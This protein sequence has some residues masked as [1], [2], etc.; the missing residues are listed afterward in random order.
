MRGGV[1]L[2]HAERE[3][4]EEELAPSFHRDG[5]LDLSHRDRA[6]AAIT[7]TVEP[8]TSIETGDGSGTT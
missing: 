5:F 8:R 1:Q 3:R 2:G 6:P 4:G 7:V